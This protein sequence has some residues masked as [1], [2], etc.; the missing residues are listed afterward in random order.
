MLRPIH[1]EIPVDDP[2]KAIQFYSSLF[3]WKFTKWDG[4]LPY[5]LISTGEGPGIDGGLLIK[6]DPSQPAVNTIDVPNLDEHLEKVEAAG[7]TVVV[8]KVTI[9]GVGWLAY[10]KDLDNNITGMMQTDPSAA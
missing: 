10:F 1:F 9:P 6:R 3:G 4:P 5:W 2:D 7:G 8:P